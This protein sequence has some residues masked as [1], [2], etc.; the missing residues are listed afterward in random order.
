MCYRRFSGGLEFDF[1]PYNRAPAPDR[2]A[3]QGTY[4]RFI[5]EKLG[6][7]LTK[8][9]KITRNG[10]ARIADGRRDERRVNARVRWHGWP[11]PRLSVVGVS[12]LPAAYRAAQQPR[13]LLELHAALHAEVELGRQLIAGNRESHVA[14]DFDL[15]R[16]LD[17]SA[18]FAIE[19]DR[20]LGRINFQVALRHLGR[21]AGVGVH[22]VRDR[23]SL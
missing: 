1:L 11:V 13:S 16:A 19:E 23:Q 21:R 15:A 4:L 2:C 20:A 12:L 17:D 10:L 18:Q 9:M 5:R 7:N 6:Q 22:R 3:L 8:L 14:R